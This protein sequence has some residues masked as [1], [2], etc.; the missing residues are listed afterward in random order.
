M[1]EHVK[2]NVSVI[3]EEINITIEYSN[4]VGKPDRPITISIHIYEDGKAMVRTS[5]P[6]KFIESRFKESELYKDMVKYF[7][8]FFKEN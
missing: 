6:Y 2:H 3:F 7:S 4:W 1:I 8:N 5:A